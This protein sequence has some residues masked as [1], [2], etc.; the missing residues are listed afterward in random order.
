MA[1]KGIYKGRPWLEWPASNKLVNSISVQQICP[2][3]AKNADQSLCMIQKCRHGHNFFEY[4]NHQGSLW[5]TKYRGEYY[6][7]NV[8]ILSPTVKNLHRLKHLLEVKSSNA[9]EMEPLR[10]MCPARSMINQKTYVQPCC[11][12]P[13]EYNIKSL[14]QRYI[15]GRH[16][17]RER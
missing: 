7:K 16:R 2:L 4:P 13:S 8:Q 11:Y 5:N 10:W 17:E 14:M 12:F 1:F 15:I 3:I 9:F 6:T